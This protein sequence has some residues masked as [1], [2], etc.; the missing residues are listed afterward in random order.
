MPPNIDQ[1]VTF[2]RTNDLEPTAR[3]YEEVVSSIIVSC[4]I[5][6]AIRSRSSAFFILSQGGPLN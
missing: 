2:L 3:F 1:Q 6:V 4:A 5:P